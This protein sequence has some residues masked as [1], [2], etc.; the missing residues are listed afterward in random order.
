MSWECLC[1]TCTR[2]LLDCS[3]QDDKFLG[4]YNKVKEEN[5]RGSTHVHALPSTE[6]KVTFF[7]NNF[8]YVCEGPQKTRCSCNMR[9]QG[10]LSCLC[11]PQALQLLRDCVQ[12]LAKV[13]DLH[14]PRR[15]FL[16]VGFLCSALQT[17]VTSSLQMLSCSSHLSPFRKEQQDWLAR[18]SVLQHQDG[19]QREIEDDICKLHAAL[20]SNSP[21]AFRA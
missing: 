8:G 13:H 7:A 2:C 21:A 11:F 3:F 18:T 17:K 6:S 20:T 12:L 15:N 10:A 14:L 19:V 1:G 16:L 5:I 4:C 9:F